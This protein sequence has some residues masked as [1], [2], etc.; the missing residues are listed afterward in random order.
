MWISLAMVKED[1]LIQAGEI[2]LIAAAAALHIVT[3]WLFA[4]RAWVGHSWLWG[5]AVYSI[6]VGMSWFYIKDQ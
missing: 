5:I 3:I 2:S 6:N 4:L 1:Y